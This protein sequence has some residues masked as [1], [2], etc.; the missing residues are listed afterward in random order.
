LEIGQFKDSF[1][2]LDNEVADELK[3]IEKYMDQNRKNIL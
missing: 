3:G 1:R 2:I